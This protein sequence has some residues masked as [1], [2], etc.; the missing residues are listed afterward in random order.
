MRIFLGG[1]CNGSKWRDELTAKLNT[2]DYFNPVVSDWTPECQKEEL[3]QRDI[4]E[5]V[6]YVIT[7]LMAGV[8]SVAEVV[9]DS[10]KRK[11]V[12]LCVLG[13]DDDHRWT[14]SQ[15]RSL[16][17]V[18]KLVQDNG[19]TVCTTLNG[20]ARYLNERVQDEPKLLHNR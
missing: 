6:V 18:A 17:A 10:N 9:D 8:Y 11:G 5:Y 15:A 13:D 1:T 12:V 20:L 16:F 3:R 19:G 14:D 7:P 4:A 2:Y